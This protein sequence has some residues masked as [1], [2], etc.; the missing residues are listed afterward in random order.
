[1]GDVKTL[2]S[3]IRQYLAGP[4]RPVLAERV[5]GTFT[6]TGSSE[7][8]A[9][10]ESIALA[11][12]DSGLGPGDRVGLMSPNRLDWIVANH[13][14][15]TAGCVTVPIYPTQALDQ[16]QL[17]LDDSG[18][19]L[20][21]V[22]RAAAKERLS[23]GGV[24]T[25]PVVLFDHDGEGGLA[26][27][28]RRGM[29]LR[30]A[31]PSAAE[32]FAAATTPEQLAVLI[33]TSGTTGTPKGVMLSHSNISS[34]A[35]S[36]FSL[37]PDDLPGD[38]PVLSVLPYAHIYEHTNL[39]GYLIRHSVVHICHSP[40]DLL[41]DL[42]TVKPVAFCAVPRIFERMLAGIVGRSRAEGG[43][44][45]KLVPWALAT[46]REYMRAQMLGKGASASQR[47]QYALARTLV[48]RK[49]RPLLGLDRL[50]FVATGSAPLHNDIAL[51][52]EAADVTVLEGYGLTECSPV[53]T[54][55]TTK[56]RKFG[57]V[58]R[59]IP[60]VE[61]KLGDDGELFVRGPNVMEGYYHDSVATDLTIHD[62]WLSTGDIAEIDSDGFV[63]ITD[64]KKE[65][66]K[67]SG[68]KFVAPARVES[69]ILRS[70]YVNQIMVTGAGRAHPAALVSPN[71]PVLRHELHIHDEV[72]T[73]QAAQLPA[74]TEFMTKELTTQ[75]AD[76]GPFEQIR[77]VGVLP[78]DLTVDDGEL[79]PTLKIR[80][81]VVEQRYAPL[82]E[83]VYGNKPA[84]V[85]AGV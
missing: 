6:Y 64:R 79:S 58:G 53:V 55:N 3:L 80:R 75:T 16:V 62:G 48:L 60:G 68:G 72:P 12:R 78:R 76:L 20:L 30:A 14:I 45:A 15:L 40:D 49:L 54:C 82:I 34:N 21:F 17:I 73:E 1:M 25:P 37:M 39:Y 7:L 28:E 85:P 47:L 9:R 77:L 8:L 51:T 2:A 66:F 57:T 19:K 11:L 26:A 42:R 71:W 38:D 18:A 41:E 33:Y 24:K 69:A 36:A 32:R 84:K 31:D 4:D 13:G 59:A 5:D 52:L 70:I 27:L 43:L 83:A 67:T 63:R 65:L 56:D 61:L 10:I 50:K 23:T 44:R 74:V 35:E 22:D 46:G 81:R 29:Q